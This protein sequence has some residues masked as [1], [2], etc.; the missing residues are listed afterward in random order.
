MNSEFGDDRFSGVV[1]EDEIA[2]LVQQENRGL[3]V[4]KL[5]HDIKASLIRINDNPELTP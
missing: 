5:G 4:G 3:D 1:L 2:I